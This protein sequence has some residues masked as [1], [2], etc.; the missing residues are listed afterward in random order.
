M[1]GGVPMK[2][3]TETRL[4]KKALSLLLALALTFCLAVPALAA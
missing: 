2:G 4:P 3:A 1:K